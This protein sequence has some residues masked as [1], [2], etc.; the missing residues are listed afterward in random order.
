MNLDSLLR[1]TIIELMEMGHSKD[2]QKTAL[3]VLVESIIEDVYSSNE[4]KS[5]S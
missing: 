3:H 4:V 2:S 1:L 5:I